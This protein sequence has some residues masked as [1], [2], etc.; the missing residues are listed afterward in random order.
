MAL[1]VKSCA[2][3]WV[4]VLEGLVLVWIWDLKDNLGQ[5]VGKCS[6]ALGLD[7]RRCGLVVYLWRSSLELGLVKI[8]LWVLK[9]VL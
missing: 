7:L 4:W 5:K 1:G 9:L 8:W 6:L 3:N 2:L